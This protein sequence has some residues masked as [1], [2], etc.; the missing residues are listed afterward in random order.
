MTQNDRRNLP[1]HEGALQGH[2]GM[3]HET[4]DRP[5]VTT[6]V[7]GVRPRRDAAWL[8]PCLVP[9]ALVP[10]QRV[11]MAR[12]VPASVVP[13]WQGGF[14]PHEGGHE[15]T[16]LSD[17]AQSQG[18]VSGFC[19]FYSAFE[20]SLVRYERLVYRQR[21]NRPVPCCAD[22]ELRA[23]DYVPRREHVPN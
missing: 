13:S 14:L 23:G 10:L 12:Q 9:S 1:C 17:E 15:G 22:G 16:R 21:R 19:W 20:F 4:G 7:D 5:L 8:Q 6:A 3:A 18:S 11:L 2:E